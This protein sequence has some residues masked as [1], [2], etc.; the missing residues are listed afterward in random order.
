M[1]VRRLSQPVVLFVAI[2]FTAL[3][4]AGAEPAR[5]LSSHEKTARE[6]YRALGGAKTAEAG[7]E[8]M[9]GIVTS[10]PELAPYQDVFRAWYKKVFSGDELETEMA[11][12]YM[13]AFT[14]DE[15][16]GLIAFYATPLGR[17]S[18]EK[19]PELMKQGA[20]LGMSRAQEHSAELEEMIATA[21]KEREKKTPA[22]P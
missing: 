11:A 4:V 17:K 21:R 10:N 22:E 2:S 3:T 1:N 18:L 6:L 19:F 5:P 9:M 15:L 20:E 12:I 13:K 14:E 16:K 8:A 7:A